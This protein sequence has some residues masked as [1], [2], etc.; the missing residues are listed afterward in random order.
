MLPAP[1]LVASISVSRLSLMFVN[2]TLRL[3]ASNNLGV[4]LHVLTNI[5]LAGAVSACTLRLPMEK[6]QANYYQKTR[7]YPQ[8]SRSSPHPHGGWG[9]GVF[10]TRRRQVVDAPIGKDPDSP[11]TR[12]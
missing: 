8:G 1:D 5:A 7:G 10:F 2:N 11:S 3:P 4:A 6:S 12:V 9:G